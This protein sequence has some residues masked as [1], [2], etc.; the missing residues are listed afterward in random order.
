MKCQ[1]VTRWFEVEGNVGIV[2]ILWMNQ[3]QLCCVRGGEQKEHRLK[4]V[5]K[6]GL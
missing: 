5:Q 6:E 1:L 2:V 4:K 3:H